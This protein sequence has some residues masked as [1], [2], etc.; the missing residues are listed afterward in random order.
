MEMS[1]CVCGLARSVYTGRKVPH[2]P[3]AA[4]IY[5]KMGQDGCGG[6]TGERGERDGLQA[7]FLAMMQSCPG[8]DPECQGRGRSRGPVGR[9][10][11]QERPWPGPQEAGADGLGDAA[12]PR[13]MGPEDPLT[14][15]RRA[16]P[17]GLGADQHS[18]PPPIP[19][20]ML[21]PSC[22]G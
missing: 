18:A 2:L 8:P 12:K 6:P 22:D 9:I 20:L 3:R 5:V 16:V 4:L 15:G 10:Q 19:C 14:P 21:A 17:G 7:D 1:P 13:T 11:T